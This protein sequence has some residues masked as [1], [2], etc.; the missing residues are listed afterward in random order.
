MSLRSFLDRVE[1]RAKK[2]NEVLEALDRLYREYSRAMKGEDDEFS[3][4]L[5]ALMHLYG[6]WKAEADHD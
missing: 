3:E 5:P 4:A 6:E 1:K 2:F